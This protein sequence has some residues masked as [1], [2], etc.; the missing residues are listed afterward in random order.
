MSKRRR[1]RQAEKE[2]IVSEKTEVR[3]SP[4]PEPLATPTDL[5]SD[6]ER[7]LVYAPR[8]R[9]SPIVLRPDKPDTETEK[10]HR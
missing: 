1:Y 5:S 3:L 2:K 8:P 6:D 4:S 9:S 10:P 7:N